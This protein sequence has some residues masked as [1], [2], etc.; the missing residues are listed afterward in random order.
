MSP[1][2][3]NFMNG[4]LTDMPC[5]FYETNVFATTT[6]SHQGLA[7]FRGFIQYHIEANVLQKTIPAI[8]YVN[9]SLPS[10]AA[11]SPLVPTPPVGI[12]L[13]GM[14]EPGNKQEMH[15]LGFTEEAVGGRKFYRGLAEISGLSRVMQMNPIMDNGVP[16][17]LADPP[18]LHD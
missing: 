15:S 1:L 18:G 10:M 3:T 11:Y 9:T 7:V 2:P 13:A 17:G 16:M 12:A 4:N 14:N 5:P 8:G 6:A